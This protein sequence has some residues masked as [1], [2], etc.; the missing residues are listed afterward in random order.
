M[1]LPDDGRLSALAFDLARPERR[2]SGD[3]F[4]AV[5]RWDPEGGPGGCVR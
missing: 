5:T 1:A 4:A 2:H 3:R